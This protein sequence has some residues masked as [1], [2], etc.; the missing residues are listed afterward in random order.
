VQRELIRR[1]S[2]EPPPPPSAPITNSNVTSRRTQL[3]FNSAQQRRLTR[4]E[5]E[6]LAADLR[7]TPGRDEEELPFV[8]PDEPNQ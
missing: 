8:F 3:A 4:A 7:L 1:N 6:Q 5:R 2:K